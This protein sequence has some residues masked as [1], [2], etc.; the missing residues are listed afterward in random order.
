MQIGTSHDCVIVAKKCTIHHLRIL[1]KE[2]DKG[3]KITKTQGNGRQIDFEEVLKQNISWAM[4]RGIEG[5]YQI[6]IALDSA[7]ITAGVYR[8]SMSD[9]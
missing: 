3:V 9:S 8:R 7:N 1:R 4:K 5:P 2:C 6:K